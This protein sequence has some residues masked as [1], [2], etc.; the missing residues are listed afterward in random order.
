MGEKEKV[1][2]ISG[3]VTYTKIQVFEGNISMSPC[4]RNDAQGSSPL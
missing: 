3:D 1:T 2:D 4:F